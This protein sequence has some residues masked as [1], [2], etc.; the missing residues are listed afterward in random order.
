MEMEYIV[1]IAVEGRVKVKV[2][3]ANSFEDAKTK[4]EAEVSDMDFGPLE[5][6]EWNAVNAE[7]ETGKFKA[8]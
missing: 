1:S 5:D 7:D 8:Y 3:G 6:I 2:K 4:A